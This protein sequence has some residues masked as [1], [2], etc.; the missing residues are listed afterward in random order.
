M[1]AAKS[2]YSEIFPIH[3]GQG[4]SLMEM[5]YTPVNDEMSQ[6]ESKSLYSI[7]PRI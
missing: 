5:K 2:S 6:G 3:E 1:I 7:V 4:E